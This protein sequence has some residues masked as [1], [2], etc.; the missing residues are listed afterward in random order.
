MNVSWRIK[1]LDKGTQFD[2]QLQLFCNICVY[3]VPFA[4][5]SRMVGVREVMVRFDFIGMT[6]RIARHMARS[7][8]AADVE[9]AWPSLCAMAR[10]SA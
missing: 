8:E 9:S 4:T 7:P 3:T 1:P 5:N 6:F 10:R 2:P